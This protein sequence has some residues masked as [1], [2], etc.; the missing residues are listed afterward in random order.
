[1]RGVIVQDKVNIKLASNL[2]LNLTQKAQKFLASMTR[3]SGS[4]DPTGCHIQSGKERS[5]TVPIVVMAPT[6][7]ATRSHWQHGLTALEGL[8]LA[9]FVHTEHQSIVGWVPIESHDVAHLV[10]KVG[11]LGKSEDFLAMRLQAESSPDT[12]NGLPRKSYPR[13]QRT[14]APMGGSLRGFFQSGAQHPLNLLVARR[15]GAPVRGISL[16]PS[17]PKRPNRLRQ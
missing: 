17:S 6:L 11:V 15:R 1:M 12:M 16:K 4:N 8:D 14:R 7:G 3:F 9:L 5:G 10:D 13:S 2:S